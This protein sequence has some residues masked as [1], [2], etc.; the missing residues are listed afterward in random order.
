MKKTFFYINRQL[1][2]WMGILPLVLLGAWTMTACSLDE[3][4]KDQIEEEQLY[5]TPENLF[6]HTVATLYSFI[7]GNKD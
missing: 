5:N 3:S 2:R 4:P 1:H 6:R 7:G